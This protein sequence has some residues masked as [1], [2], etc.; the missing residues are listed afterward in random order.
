MYKF[1]PCEVKAL[2]RYAKKRSKLFSLPLL[3]CLDDI[4]KKKGYSNWSLLKKHSLKENDPMRP[5]TLLD[6]ESVHGFK[7]ISIPTIRCAPGG[8]STKEN[9]GE[10]VYRCP[11]CSRVHTHEVQNEW[12]GSGDG[13]SSPPCVTEEDKVVLDLVETLEPVWAGDIP[14]E[15]LKD[16]T[17]LRGRAHILAWFV[18]AH[19]LAV[20]SSPYETREGGYQ[21]PIIED[22][23]DIHETLYYKFEDEDEDLLLEL[24]EELMD[25]GPWL[26][27]QFCKAREYDLLADPYPY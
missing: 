26:T 7:I 27:S 20:N 2:N 23:Y 16:Y 15:Y 19:E 25:E 4:A 5:A 9:P 1:S 21:F 22:T 17:P 24:A 18:H 14:P 12:F 6:E 3:Q 11:L 13:F 8:Q 10:L